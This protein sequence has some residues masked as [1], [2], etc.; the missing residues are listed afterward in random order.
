MALNKWQLMNSAIGKR[1]LEIPN[2]KDVECVSVGEDYRVMV[3]IELCEGLSE[4]ENTDAHNEINAAI[5]EVLVEVD[6][7]LLP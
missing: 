3:G 2:V 7:L 4:K 5:D 1:L 6:K